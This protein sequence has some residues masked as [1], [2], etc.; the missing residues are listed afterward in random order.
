MISRSYQLMMCHQLTIS[1]AVTISCWPC[2]I[3]SS[4]TF[5]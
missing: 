3:N 2:V 4:Q 5:S 1:S